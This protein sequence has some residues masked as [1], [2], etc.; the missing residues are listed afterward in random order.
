MTKTLSRREWL[1]IAGNVTLVTAAGG[2]L[3]PRARAE[4]VPLRVGT[5]GASDPQNYARA[6][7]DFAKLFAGKAK[8]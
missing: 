1:K 7:D 2:M 8:V 4:E 3:L 6:T 5:F